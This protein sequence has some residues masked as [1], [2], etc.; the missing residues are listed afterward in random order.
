MWWASPDIVKTFRT[1]LA[2]GVIQQSLLHFQI[3]YGGN[4]PG[5]PDVIM[6]T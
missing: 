4:P 5:L 3:Q 6:M 1:D 2:D